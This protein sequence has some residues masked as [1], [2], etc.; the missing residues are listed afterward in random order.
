MVPNQAA[1]PTAA[2]TFENPRGAA[3]VQ[4]LTKV[5]WHQLQHRLRQTGTGTGMSNDF[6]INTGTG[7]CNSTISKL[8]GA[9][10]PAPAQASSIRNCQ[11]PAPAQAPRNLKMHRNLEVFLSRCHFKD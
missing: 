11:A 4:A 10:K 1:R 5:E 3:P 9:T 8:T 7:T 2:L 6:F